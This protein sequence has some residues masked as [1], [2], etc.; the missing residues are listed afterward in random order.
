MRISFDVDDTLVCY[1]PGVPIEQHV[2]WWCRPWYT[3]RL[4]RGTRELMRELLR[5]GCN[6][7]IYTTSYRSPLYLRWWFRSL[8]IRLAGVV[9][10]QIHEQVVKW[11]GYSG[12]PPSKYPPAFGI[13]LHVDDSE[14]VGMEGEQYG[15]AVVVVSP[16]DLQWTER[17]LEA[18]EK[19]MCGR[20]G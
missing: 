16:Q 2:P 1:D 6:L 20:P 18:V 17:I 11:R 19:R 7:W 8:G 5:R 15:F 10:Q 4:R 12:Y 14:G 3:E 9:N 13:D